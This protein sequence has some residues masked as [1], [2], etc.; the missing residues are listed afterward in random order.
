MERWANKELFLEAMKR[1]LEK[2]IEELRE[3]K[4]RTPKTHSSYA[5][6]VKALNIALRVNEIL[7]ELDSFIRKA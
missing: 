2:L 6:I 1:L 4:K 5:N 3:A 7:S